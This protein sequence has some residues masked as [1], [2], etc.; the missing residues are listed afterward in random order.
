M[1]ALWFFET[2]ETDH[3]EMQR[4][5]PEEDNCQSHLCENLKLALKKH[6]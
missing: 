6:T 5:E 2:S 3:P 4:H 1:Q